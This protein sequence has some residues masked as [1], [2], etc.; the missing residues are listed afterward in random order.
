MIHYSVLITF[1][2]MTEKD[3]G[4]DLDIN[5]L[6]TSTHLHIFPNEFIVN[7]RFRGTYLKVSLSFIKFVSEVNTNQCKFHLNFK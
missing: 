7:G 3:F 2:T 5:N 4:I 1:Q 6:A